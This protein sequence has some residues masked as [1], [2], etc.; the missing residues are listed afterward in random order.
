MTTEFDTIFVPLAQELLEEFGTTVILKE[1]EP[2]GS[3][4]AKLGR[5]VAPVQREFTIKIIPPDQFR[6]FYTDSD[7]T[8]Q[9]N[10]RSGFAAKDLEFTPT[11][12][13]ILI[14]KGEEWKD[15]LFS[16]IYSGDEIALYLME[17]DK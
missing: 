15:T 11:N 2:V 17:F 3:Y 14:L 4:D 1:R 12:G 8:E 13:M 5:T 9:S 16:P 7:L 10:M 6:Q